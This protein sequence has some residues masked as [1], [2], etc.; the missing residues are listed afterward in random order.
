MRIVNI[1]VMPLC[2]GIP[3]DRSIQNI[4]ELGEPI[5]CRHRDDREIAGAPVKPPPKGTQLRRNSVSQG[6][7]TVK[8]DANITSP[9]NDFELSSGKVHA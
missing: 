9:R 5:R 1:P 8:M 3:L 6:M 2:T 7:W 4:L